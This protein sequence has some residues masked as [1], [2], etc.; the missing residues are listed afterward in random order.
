MNCGGS[1][2]VFFVSN[3]HRIKTCNSFEFPKI[4]IIL[5]NWFVKRWLILYSFRVHFTKISESWVLKS[6]FCFYSSAVICISCFLSDDVEWRKEKRLANSTKERFFSHG[7]DER[8][9]FQLETNNLEIKRH[10]VSLT[11]LMCW[12]KRAYKVKHKRQSKMK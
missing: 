7:R 3:V 4:F 5:L 2:V 12:L 1:Q 11:V 6:E 8:G 10:P 9:D